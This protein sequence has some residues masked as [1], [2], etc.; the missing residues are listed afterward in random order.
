MGVEPI[1]R[2]SLICGQSR[3]NVKRHCMF[4]SH[5]ALPSGSSVDGRTTVASVV[6]HADG[7]LSRVA[8]ARE[9]FSRIASAF[10]VH[11]ILLGDLLCSA[12]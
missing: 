6:S 8:L 1:R 12:M 11:T 5:H 2:N 4:I 9:I 3:E 10:F 7:I